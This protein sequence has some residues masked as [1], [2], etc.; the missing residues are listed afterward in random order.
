MS[1]RTEMK[2]LRRLLDANDLDLLLKA[3]PGELIGCILCMN[4]AARYRNA[5]DAIL[6]TAS[7]LEVRCSP[8]QG[9]P[10]KGPSR[11]IP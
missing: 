6:L 1:T 2:H 9:Y 11:F 4:R 5:L 7:L 10:R 8:E 3:E